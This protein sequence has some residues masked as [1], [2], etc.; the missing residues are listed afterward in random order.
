MEYFRQNQ[1]TKILQIENFDIQTILK[2]SLKDFR[3]LYKVYAQTTTTA[4]AIISTTSQEFTAVTPDTSSGALNRNPLARL[5]EFGEDFEGES[6]TDTTPYETTTSGTSGTG[7]GTS[8]TGSTVTT[9]ASTTS[10]GGTGSTEI[11][12][13]DGSTVSSAST[14]EMSSSL[15]ESAGT[16]QLA[17]ST[18]DMALLTVSS[19]TT[20]TTNSK[21]TNAASPKVSKQDFTSTT[22]TTSPTS[23]DKIPRDDVLPDNDFNLSATEKDSETTTYVSESTTEPASVS[24]T[25][26]DKS[27]APNGPTTAYETSAF[28]TTTTDALTD[29]LPGESVEPIPAPIPEPPFISTPPTSPNTEAS[30]TTKNVENAIEKLTIKPG[31]PNPGQSDPTN[32]E[33]SVVTETKPQYVCTTGTSDNEVDCDENRITDKDREAEFTEVNR[34]CKFR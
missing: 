23:P 30:K 8:G 20:S 15:A 31:V 12:A 28:T 16:S 9:G 27:S 11:T 17:S 33:P 4:T 1:L 19:E 2:W 5:D 29:A 14:W 21:S 32:E 26:T 7:T 10:T 22:S 25:T 6:S 34:K 24:T 13:T 18:T 3:I